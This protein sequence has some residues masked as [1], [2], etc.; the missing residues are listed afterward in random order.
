MNDAT[1]KPRIL[2]PAPG[3]LAFYEGRVAG[4]RFAPEPNWVDEG[5][6]GLGIAGYAILD[7]EEALVYDT[8]VSVDY[9]SFVRDE[10]SR[11]GA[12]RFTV[13]LSHW[14]LD[15]VAGTAAFAGAEVL[16]GA[17]TA[18]H[19]RER[20]EAIE[21][22]TLEGP[23][24]IS[25]LILPTRVLAAGESLRVGDTVVETIAVNIHSDDATVLW[26]PEQRLLLAGDTMEDTVTYVDEPGEF[27]AHLRDLERLRALRPGRILPAHGDPDQIAVGGY[28]PG[29]NHATQSYIRL[30]QRVPS[31][32]DLR[33]VPLR[34]LI[35]DP[36]AAGDLIYF[37]PYEAVHRENVATVLA[38]AGEAD[39]GT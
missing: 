2:E 37:E 8:G 18:E 22:G 20:R 29:F 31:E 10:L 28:P 34:E 6:L 17:P 36:L 4:R 27:D 21:A 39:Q 23:P 5:A 7:G 15:H 13:L 24:T 1:G 25:P 14:H 38:A 3:V 35:A 33:E 11:R 32:P 30:L 16:A 9:G 12:T 26:L 19:L